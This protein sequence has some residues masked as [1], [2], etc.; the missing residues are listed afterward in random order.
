MRKPNSSPP[1][2][3]WVGKRPFTVARNAAFDESANSASAYEPGANL[4]DQRSR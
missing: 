3:L 2:S 1:R 4:R